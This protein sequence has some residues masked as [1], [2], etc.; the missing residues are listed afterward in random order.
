LRA[1]GSLFQ[2]NWCLTL[3]VDY[4]PLA[5]EWISAPAESLSYEQNTPF[6]TR[7]TFLPRYCFGRGARGDERGDGLRAPF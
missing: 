5:G 2:L 4:G 7:I 3:F 1:A 6:L